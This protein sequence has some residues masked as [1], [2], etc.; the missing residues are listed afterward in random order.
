[1]IFSAVIALASVG[2]ASA[3]KM[4]RIHA[5]IEQLQPSDAFFLVDELDIHL[6]AKV[7]Y[8][9]TLILICCGNS[10]D[11]LRRSLYRY[12]DSVKT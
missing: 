10:G 2:G 8:Q 5:V 4:A 7:C 1:M 11:Y 6:L 9:S 12:R 3:G